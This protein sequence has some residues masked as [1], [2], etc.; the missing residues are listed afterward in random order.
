MWRHGWVICAFCCR[1]W[2]AV[3]P[4]EA[5]HLE[6]PGCHFHTTPPDEED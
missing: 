2:M 1:R 6:C 5:R 4:V 3:W